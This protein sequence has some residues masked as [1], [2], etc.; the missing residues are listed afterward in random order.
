MLSY[1]I[2]TPARCV[3]YVAALAIL[4]IPGSV[5]AGDVVAPVPELGSGAALTAV[6]V[7]A[8]VALIFTNRR[9]SK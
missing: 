5:Y 7:M 2:G 3:G 9:S 1:F 6:A 8:G 4:A